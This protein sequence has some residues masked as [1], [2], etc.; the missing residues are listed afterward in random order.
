[1]SSDPFVTPSRAG[2]GRLNADKQF[3]QFFGHK[4]FQIKWQK[5][6][7]AKKR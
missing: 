1:M 7:S 5:E 4:H 3:K 2:R 6:L